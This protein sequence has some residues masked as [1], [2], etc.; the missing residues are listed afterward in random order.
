MARVAPE[1]NRV[2]ARIRPAYWSW[3]LSV[4]SGDRDLWVM[5]DTGLY[6]VD[7]A[8]SRVTSA[9][10]LRTGVALSGDVATGH[11]SVWVHDGRSGTVVRLRA[12]RRAAT[13]GRCRA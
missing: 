12:G 9:L 13:G 10:A 11:G 2:V 1:T 5:A 7:P 6:R 3:S 8:T 4:V